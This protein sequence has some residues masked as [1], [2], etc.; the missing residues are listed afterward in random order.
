[1]P[2]CSV[3]ACGRKAIA[4][5]LCVGHYQRLKKTG[6]LDPERPIGFKSGSAN[7]NWKGGIVTKKDGRV[8]VYSP[9]HPHAHKDGKYVLRY[10]LKMEEKLGRILDPSEPVHH[11]NNSTSNDAE[12]NLTV[13][14][15]QAVH[16]KLHY[17]SR[18]RNE[19]SQFV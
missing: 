2:V 3:N 18:A 11:A 1:M 13:L 14:P 4:K 16:A 19:K 15:N 17:A 6:K 5:G 8:L 7:P 12:D 9:G 10:R